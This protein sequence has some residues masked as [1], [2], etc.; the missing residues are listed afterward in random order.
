[1]VILL[2]GLSTVLLTGLIGIVDDLTGLRQLVKTLLPVMVA[3]P[4]M[5]VRAGQT[6]L[7]LPWVG[8]ANQG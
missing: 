7:K 4:L 2:A 8:G 1:M 5:V 6:T 3:L